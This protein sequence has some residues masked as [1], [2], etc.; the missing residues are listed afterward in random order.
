MT[1]HVS[2]EVAD[3]KHATEDAEAARR[4]AEADAARSAIENA[5][6]GDLVGPGGGCSIPDTALRGITPDQLERPIQHVKRRLDRGEV[7]SYTPNYPG[8]PVRTIRH[9]EEVN[10]YD[11]DALVIRPATKARQCSM[12]CM[13]PFIGHLA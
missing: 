7:L 5:D 11:L 10:L 9:I 12:V 8:A 1:A 13:I 3:E 6:F 2:C 4:K